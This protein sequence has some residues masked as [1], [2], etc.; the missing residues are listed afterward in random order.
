MKR[1]ENA[2]RRKIE[3]DERKENKGFFFLTSFSRNIT[4]SEIVGRSAEWF[5][6]KNISNFR[7]R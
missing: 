7:K 3:E 6:N 1:G 4:D 5:R 2:R